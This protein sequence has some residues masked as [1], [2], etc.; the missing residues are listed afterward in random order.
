MKVSGSDGVPVDDGSAGSS[1]QGRSSHRQ[2]RRTGWSTGLSIW[3]G[4]LLSAGGMFAILVG[5]FLFAPRCTPVYLVTA[6]NYSRPF[7]PY[8]WA[9][10]DAARL[11][12]LDG[13]TLSLHH[14]ESGVES[15]DDF[16]D[17]F[18]HASQHSSG[19]SPSIL[20]ISMHGLAENDGEGL[21][22]V[23]PQA[24]AFETSKW[25]DLRDVLLQLNDSSRASPT[26][27]I[28]DCNRIQASWPLG[29]KANPMVRRVKELIQSQRL[30]NLSV[31]LPCDEQQSPHVSEE[32]QASV[33]G[34]FLH[35]GL[36]GAAD[37]YEM[38][39]QD[40]WVSVQ[41]LHAFVKKHVNHWT[42]TNRGV[43]QEPVLIA[44]E[45]SEETRL[46]RAMN[47]K[48]VD[49]LVFEE[50]QL[51]PD[52]P[53]L[54]DA[55]LD[56]LWRRFDS[57]RAMRLY[58]NE[59]VAFA[60]LEHEL[61]WL[62]KL[63]IAGAGYRALASDRYRKLFDRLRDIEHRA[64]DERQTT[65][66]TGRASVI[67]GQEPRLPKF[68]FAHSLP[69][70]QAL[71]TV[72]FDSVV[73]AQDRLNALVEEIDASKVRDTLQSLEKVIPTDVAS[74]R[75]L[76]MIDR[77]QNE[78]TWDQAGLISDLLSLQMRCRTLASL[79]AASGGLRQVAWTAEIL[80]VLDDGRRA[81]E[82]CLIASGNL[83]ESLRIAESLYEQSEQR[84]R[85]LSDSFAISDRALAE[86]TYL[87]QWM[88]AC[89]TSPYVT[90]E[91]QSNHEVLIELLRASQTLSSRLAAIDSEIAG[92]IDN[93]TGEQEAPRTLDEIAAELSSIQAFAKS[94]VA[95]PLDVLRNRF[96]R[97][98]RSFIEQ[99]DSISPSQ[100]GELAALLE[101]PLLAWEER[102]KLRGIYRQSSVA[103][104]SNDPDD[105]THTQQATAND[106]TLPVTFPIHPLDVLL[107][108]ASSW[109]DSPE[110]L[111]NVVQ[112]MES[113]RDRLLQRGSLQQRRR[114][115]SRVAISARCLAPLYC[116]PVARRVSQDSLR[117][118]LQIA[119]VDAANRA[120]EDFWGSAGQRQDFFDMSAS[121]YLQS[122][123]DIESMRQEFDISQT[124]DEIRGSQTQLEDARKLAA[125]WIRTEPATA[126]QLGSNESAQTSVLLAS[127]L[128]NPD[129]ITPEGT[130]VVVVRQPLASPNGVEAVAGNVRPGAVELPVLG[131]EVNLT[132]P[133]D[134][135]RSAGRL[136]A[137]TVFRGHEYNGSLAVRK[138]GGR[139]IET[140]HVPSK[141]SE[142]AL[143]GETDVVSVVL[144]LDCSASMGDPFATDAKGP[145]KLSVAKS[146]L[147]SL[148]MELGLRPSINV[149]VRFFGHRVGWSKDSSPQKVIRPGVGELPK[150]L[151]PSRDVETVFQLAPLPLTDA[152][153]LI[154]SMTKVQP[155]GQ[156]PLYLS[157]VESI[158]TLGTQSIASD[159]HVIV[160]TDGGNYQFIPNDESTQPTSE[161]D[162]RS[163]FEQ[164]GIPV[165]ILGL[166]MS[167]GADASTVDELTG[168]CRDSGGQFISLNQSPDLIAALRQLLKPA[169]YQVASLDQSIPE[170][171]ASLGNSVRI[172]K[173]S[174]NPTLHQVKTNTRKVANGV[175]SAGT[176]EFSSEGTSPDRPTVETEV[177][178]EGGEF[179]QL[180]V[181]ET[182]DR[183]QTRPYT[184]NCLAEANLVRA[185]GEVTDHVVRVHRPSRNQRGTVTFPVSWQR[186]DTRDPSGNGWLPTRR[187]KRF[188][189]EIQPLTKQDE[190]GDYEPD[191]Q[192]YVFY[193][194][195]FVAQQN[196]PRVDLSAHLWPRMST[197]AHIRI[198]T[199][200]EFE[201]GISLRAPATGGT[202]ANG[203]RTQI[204]LRDLLSSSMEL[205]PQIT[206][207]CDTT[208]PD[209]TTMDA[210]PMVSSVRL[211]A[212]F[213]ADDAS[214]SDLRFSI[215]TEYLQSVKRQFDREN[216][217]A[218]HTF[219]FRE[220]IPASDV[221]V[222]ATNRAAET[223]GAWVLEDNSLKID[224]VEP[225]ESIRVGKRPR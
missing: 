78:T 16:W 52:A 165:S 134:L 20:W 118:H 93:A 54:A 97:H 29:R 213:E 207:R 27:L 176:H 152:Q 119:L 5:L 79:N 46:V 67:S 108:S 50:S 34:H 208:V 19:R 88:M 83:A 125:T 128:D 117:V 133:P 107:Q 175:T 80:P 10:E 22:L 137:Q 40:G 187:P 162:V 222:M 211:I 105:G 43:R 191:G 73:D 82:D 158:N 36:A 212:S 116:G 115:A 198:W 58:E 9:A 201:D 195:E 199:Q 192:S 61:L 23:P 30:Q 151:T 31:L 112:A 106:P 178:L 161:V 200:F 145:S 120:L 150:G 44:P 90:S 181:N 190:S 110:Q 140:T 101:I 147:Q 136:Q 37:R 203:W 7:A 76:R 92:E 193:D 55:Q 33:F 168:L 111:G 62:E 171:S 68:R 12:Q 72:P 182:L 6:E 18:Q 172:P 217:I 85:S 69:M 219:V 143:T 173:P 11:K 71:D 35:L 183:I 96:G 64:T 186:R 70:A 3:L 156:S 49:A 99:A 114:E 24:G 184:A 188:W 38:G 131:T 63:S 60:D 102:S 129:I 177:S 189:I 135:L 163:A 194:R 166:E 204:P 94:E 144:I 14:P 21:Y 95:S 221:I 28:L 224:V 167:T 17:R 210:E 4:L 84:I 223:T 91:D 48:T 174:R 202:R 214:V 89:P 179:M 1:W 65:R 142:V 197:R 2:R 109:C 220:P 15:A 159:S 138:L 39:D 206:L 74:M 51:Q 47:A 216:H 215:Q 103:L 8:A 153:T 209:S 77:Y 98:A 86:S 66:L 26:L 121:S 155:W 205:L 160:I 126:I 32:L 180:F 123:L 149:E 45:A 25:I 139:L 59:P 100:M 141:Q 218:V 122:A 13:E 148:L 81:A 42:Q 124:P 157:L 75:Y 130:A 185:E 164:H 170:L 87:S 132:L 196:V 104:Q 225:A 169:T 53:S 146:A 57:L 127:D 154:A 56:Q 113:S 41:E